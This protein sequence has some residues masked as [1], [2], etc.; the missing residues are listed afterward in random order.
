MKKTDVKNEILHSIATLHPL[1]KWHF[2]LI[3][4]L[5]V[6][7]TIIMVIGSG[8]ALLGLYAVITNDGLQYVGYVERLSYQAGMIA[9]PILG[10]L[11][12]GIFIWTVSSLIKSLRYGY[13]IKMLWIVGIFILVSIFVSIGLNILFRDRIMSIVRHPISMVE[14]FIWTQPSRGRLSGVII[15]R[16]ENSM[17]LRDSIGYQWNV[18][19]E[20]LLPKSAAA[21]ISENKVRIVGFRNGDFVFTACQVFPWKKDQFSVSP[22]NLISNDAVY[23]FEHPKEVDT[24]DTPIQEICD[25]IID[26]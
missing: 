4:T 1:S 22:Q 5:R 26:K 19:T 8:I 14:N 3:T 21:V 17:I 7:I 23:V 18:D 12:F 24:I 11:C 9:L 10:T 13:R 25:A 20:Y 16:G 6:L 2:R 15:D